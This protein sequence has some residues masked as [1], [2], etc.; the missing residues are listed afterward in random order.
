MMGRRGIRRGIFF[1]ELVNLLVLI[2][3]GELKLNCVKARLNKFFRNINNNIIKIIENMHYTQGTAS[4]MD[5][6]RKWSGGGGLHF[7]PKV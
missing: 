1:L 3:E 6:R 7:K 2:I 4:K 5:K